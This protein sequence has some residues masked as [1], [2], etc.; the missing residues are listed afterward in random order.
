[1]FLTF[2]EYRRELPVQ[3][4]VNQCR[5]LQHLLQHK[6]GHAHHAWIEAPDYGPPDLIRPRE[7]QPATHDW[8][9]GLTYTQ[10]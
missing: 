3:D 2:L 4:Q 6:Y 9:T 10:P 1:M 5:V 8:Q 7:T